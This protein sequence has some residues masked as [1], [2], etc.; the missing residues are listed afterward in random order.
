MSYLKLYYHI[1]WRTKN[2]VP[3]ISE[4][5]EKEL[6][7]YIWGIVKSKDSYLYRINSMPDHVHMLVDI[8]PNI[9]LSD[10]M[11]QVKH[12]SG[13]YMRNHQD[14]YPLFRE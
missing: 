14:W 12:S 3:A 9:S 7:N 1:I 10:F 8:N 5:H 6:Y 2:S 4:D 13:N 11:Q